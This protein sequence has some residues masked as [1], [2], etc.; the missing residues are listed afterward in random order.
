[1]QKLHLAVFF[2]FAALSMA[3]AQCD[4]FEIFVN[5][6]SK[7]CGNVINHE[8]TFGN[9][10][11]FRIIPENGDIKWKT[12][13]DI[14]LDIIPSYTPILIEEEDNIFTYI[15]ERN[16]VQK[17]IILNF[18]ARRY[19]VSFNTGGSAVPPQSVMHNEKA[20]RPSTNPTRENY[21]FDGW[22]FDFNTLIT[23]DTVITAKWKHKPCT[24]QF[25]T[26][27]GGTIPNQTVDY[28]SR[29]SSPTPPTRAGYTF[30]HWYLS[31]ENTAFDFNTAITSD[32]KLSAKWN[33]VP[34]TITYYPND[35]TLI[36]PVVS[37][38]N[39]E[40]GRVSLPSMEE[41]CGLEFEGWLENSSLYGSPM[42]SFI[43]NANNLGNKNLYAKWTPRLKKPTAN[44]FNYTIPTGLIYNTQSV[45][46][47]ATAKAGNQCAMSN[48]ITVFYNGSTTP[49]KDAGSYAI[50]VFIAK[51][52]DY[53]SA[54][55]SLGY[56]SI[57]RKGVT[58]TINSATAKN[59]TY[60]ATTIA[61]I[62]SISFDE[63]QLFPGDKVSAN[64]YSINANF[65]SQNIGENI[66][67]NL[68]VNW[69]NNGPLSKNYILE[70]ANFK[71]TASITRAT[72]FL[73]I[74]EPER[75]VLANP[76]S[77]N[78]NKPSFV[79]AEDIIW[80][81]R[82][83]NDAN[84]SAKLPDRVGNWNVRATLPG[85]ANYTGAADSITFLVERG[86]DS[87]P[88]NIALSG[89]E[90]DAALSSKKRNYFVAKECGIE[91]TVIKITVIEPG[92]FLS[93]GKDSN[94]PVRGEEP[95]EDGSV[96]Y[97]LSPFTLG[98]FKL[99]TVFYT[100]FSVSGIEELDTILIETPIPFE[101]IAGQK[102]NN[103]LFIN[104][105]P[106]TNGGYKFESYKWFQNG[107]PVSEMQF[108]S[109]GPSSRDTLNP[110]DIYK[111]TMHTTD[112]IRVSTCEG[113]PKTPKV[114]STTAKPAL[115]KQ[116]LG[117][118]G[119][120]AK[121]GS[122]VYNLKGSRTESTPAGVYIIEE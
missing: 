121:I 93:L 66:E 80:E 69:L 91:S 5:D 85:T 38:Y 1:M 107:N 50:S 25:Q 118:N 75:Y 34:Y 44:L 101:A 108:Y 36:Q 48:D 26:G 95:Y 76:V 37:S 99:D 86:R 22:D 14:I 96:L 88:Q 15:V 20:S 55:V 92:I 31:D 89:F 71:T 39:I 70:S 61:E 3:R 63:S 73:W 52:E 120:T 8:I 4:N 51:S 13:D 29:A 59:K 35:G 41:R 58:I 79:R 62:T 30:A 43:P 7:G 81:Y 87:V 45:S 105:N 16:G 2:I 11:T 97:E 47:T 90:R 18:K 56:L 82:R 53:D 113:S 84:Y 114:L 40:S 119:K 94:N 104:N 112:G 68:R 115:T 33:V 77:L 42:T 9:A 23:K 102:W 21:D 27:G 12:E 28:G 65:A 78:A 54:T 57:G 72:G 49:P 103:V 10:L 67:V 106:Q 116:V 109:A 19:T 111:A 98:K 46:I 74:I 83:E 17:K 64:D 110:K 117:I 24:V 32:I 100:L 60:D 6:V 122:K